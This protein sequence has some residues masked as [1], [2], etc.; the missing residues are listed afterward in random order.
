MWNNALMK[1][2]LEIK[3]MDH[4]VVDRAKKVED[5]VAEGF[6]SAQIA[7]LAF[8]SDL[9]CEDDGVVPNWLYNVDIP[10]NRIKM[11]A[12]AIYD[13]NELSS[14]EAMDNE[15]FNDLL[16]D[17]K[18]ATLYK[19][20]D[21]DLYEEI[22]N[23]CCS[24]LCGF[25]IADLDDVTAAELKEIRLAY[26]NLPNVNTEQILNRLNSVRKVTSEDDK[27]YNPTKMREARLKL[28]EEI[29]NLSNKSFDDEEVEINESSYNEGETE[30]DSESESE[31]F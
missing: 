19:D 5:I 15:L 13:I 31:N 18:N 29:S 9:F 22:I 2:E 24:G 4:V 8:A 17:V 23:C 6:N 12:C 30:Y 7:A 3:P 14:F 10:A 27:L 28:Q 26:E 25:T 1:E 16:R 20:I 21:D 11:A